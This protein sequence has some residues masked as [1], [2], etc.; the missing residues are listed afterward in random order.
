M[1]TFYPIVVTLRIFHTSPGIYM[2]FIVTASK[3]AISFLDMYD[4][5]FHVRK[6]TLISPK[7]ISQTPT[8]K[9]NYL[10]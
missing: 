4:T 10:T 5:Y 7:A 3:G 9:N 8:R 2:A 1:G 6:T